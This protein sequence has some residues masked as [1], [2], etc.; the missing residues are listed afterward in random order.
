MHLSFSSGSWHLSVKHTQRLLPAKGWT[1][2]VSLESKTSCHFHWM[3]LTTCKP[4]CTPMDLLI[5]L[6]ES[7]WLF[8]F[9]CS[10]QKS[11]SPQPSRPHAT[12]YTVPTSIWTSH[13]QSHR[14]LTCSGTTDEQTRL[15]S[16]LETKINHLGSL[17]LNNK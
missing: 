6:S 15:F 5:F 9:V 8:F 7:E 4:K 3:S 16:T 13:H 10:K 1:S 11:S 17:F 12:I 14:M 2:H